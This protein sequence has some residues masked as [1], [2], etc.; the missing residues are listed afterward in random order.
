VTALS[1]PVAL[2]QALIRCPSVTPVEAGVL[3]LLEATL[4]PLGF[5]CERLPFSEAGT[6]D[7]DNLY[8][9]I[10]EGEPHFC[11]A[12]HTDVVPVG[13][14]EQWSIDPFAGEIRDGEIFGRGASDMKGAIAAFTVAAAG[15]LAAR[16]KTF[17][18]SISLL[19]TGDEE[20]PSVN[21][22]KKMLER[23]AQRGERIDACVVGEPTNPSALGEM[24]KIGRRGSMNCRLT[25][26]GVQGHIAYPDRADNPIHR[27]I[28]ML[29][30]LT[31]E[32]LDAGTAHFQPST[33]QVSTVDVGNPTTNVI[34]AEAR[35][36]FN[37]RF[38]DAHTSASLTRWIRERLDAVGGR[39][40]LDV[41]VSGE[42]FVFP[43]GRLSGLVQD[44]AEAETGRRPEL[45]TT[46]GTSDARFIQAYCPVVEFGGVGATMHQ[47]DERQR[48]ADIEA[49]ARIYRRI[50]DGFF[51][52][53]A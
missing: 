1:D 50:L 31:R 13:T 8:A 30:A 46:G 27:M 22:T 36:V 35:A 43:P 42:S 7:V 49:L 38:N 16:G 34:P 37:I 33:L 52:T 17:A 29:D 19:I 32:P 40:A 4:R 2:T 6:P 41:T 15:F 10:G 26:H 44:A 3:D 51:R 12:G 5:R 18:G 14:R 47:V 48:T 53:G 11:F 20:G 39:Y 23:L 24:M 9:R 45:S 21:G 25:V 28:R